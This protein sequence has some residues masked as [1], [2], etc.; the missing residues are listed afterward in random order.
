M[1]EFG[2]F[3]GLLVMVVISYLG[4]ISLGWQLKEAA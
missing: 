1:S 4:G 2:W 3:V